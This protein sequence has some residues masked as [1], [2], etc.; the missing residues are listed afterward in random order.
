MNH[1]CGH[2]Y[3]RPHQ[4]CETPALPGLDY[5]AE[6]L[7]SQT[8]YCVVRHCTRDQRDDNTTLCAGHYTEWE[9]SELAFET[10]ADTRHNP[11]VVSLGAAK[12]AH[13][14]K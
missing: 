10:W 1:A 3:T 2:H 6:H 12:K 4:N 13:G 8:V 9:A 7:Q 11:L 5:C 14:G